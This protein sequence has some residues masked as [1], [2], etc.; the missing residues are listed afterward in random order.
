MIQPFRLHESKDTAQ[1]EAMRKEQ[2]WKITDEELSAFEEKV[3][4]LKT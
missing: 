1:A 3:K 4:P 2:P